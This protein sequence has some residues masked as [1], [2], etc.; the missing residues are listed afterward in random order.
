V[1]GRPTALIIIPFDV[2]DTPVGLPEAEAGL[3]AAL[4]VSGMRATAAVMALP[5]RKPATARRITRIRSS[6]PSIRAGCAEDE[7]GLRAGYPGL[8]YTALRVS[9]RPL[10]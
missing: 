6:S 1:A 3:A 8:P 10:N 9:R 7:V 2:A 5:K 4:V